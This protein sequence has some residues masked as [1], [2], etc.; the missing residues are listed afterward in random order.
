MTVKHQGVCGV[1]TAPDGH[2]VAT[3]ADFERQG[4]GGFSLKEAQTIRVRE[5]LKRA[6]LRAFL[7][8]GL[9]SKTSGYFCDQFWENAAEHG[10]RMETFPI[11]YEVA[12]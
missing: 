12:A 2:V 4:Y 8:Q 10:Y 5:G 9:T 3:H 11:G 7:F 1:V 6:F